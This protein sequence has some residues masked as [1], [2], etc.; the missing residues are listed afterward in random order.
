MTYQTMI[1]ALNWAMVA[2]RAV[3]GVRWTTQLPKAR[4][5]YWVGQD[6]VEH[7]ETRR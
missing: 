5:T 6:G 7:V 2:S 4:I 3:P 1:K